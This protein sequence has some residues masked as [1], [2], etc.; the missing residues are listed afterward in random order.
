[1]RKHYSKKVALCAGVVLWNCGT[2]LQL[3]LSFCWKESRTF[4]CI[5]LYVTLVA[6]YIP[7]LWWWWT[8]GTP[9][10]TTKR[11]LQL[12]GRRE[13]WTS[14]HAINCKGWGSSK[15]QICGKSSQWHSRVHSLHDISCHPSTSLN[16]TEPQKAGGHQSVFPGQSPC[17][18][19]RI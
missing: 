16:Q 19:C 13:C 14:Q 1:M 2:E 8:P 3:S 15:L 12:G 7:E 17:G 4:W 18:S 9:S 6:L 10:S 5:T 11:W